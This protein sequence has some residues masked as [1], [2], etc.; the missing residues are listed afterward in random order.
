VP[1]CFLNDNYATNLD[2][3]GE[4]VA[5]LEINFFFIL[6][7]TVFVLSIQEVFIPTKSPVLRKGLTHACQHAYAYCTGDGPEG[8]VVLLHGNS[9][10]CK[11]RG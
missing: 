10:H 4:F 6:R 3:S 11:I 9:G 5:H 7:F 1:P 8:M 2:V